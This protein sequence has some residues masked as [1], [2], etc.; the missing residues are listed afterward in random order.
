[1]LTTNNSITEVS[2]ELYSLITTSSKTIEESYPVIRDICGSNDGH[3]I[4]LFIKDYAYGI[5]VLKDYMAKYCKK[6]LIISAFHFEIVDMGSNLIHEEEDIPD[7]ILSKLEDN[8]NRLIIKKY[9]LSRLNMDETDNI[10]IDTITEY[11][12][13][14]LAE[15]FH[16]MKF[17]ILCSSIITDY[18]S[19]PSDEELK[20]LYDTLIQLNLEYDY[21]LLMLP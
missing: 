11:Y 1:M 12:E 8:P 13:M 15:D 6:E 4:K 2:A 16:N 5:T 14:F 21:I 17:E 20:N 9:I 19:L 3:D 7:I 10:D 18:T